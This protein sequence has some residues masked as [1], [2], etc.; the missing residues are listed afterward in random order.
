MRVVCVGAMNIDIQGF[1]KAPINMRD[2]NPGRIE[3]CPGGVTRNIAENMARLGLDV[4]MVSVTGDDDFGRIIRDSCTAVGMDI[5]HV[6]TLPGA[7]SSAYL[8]TTDADG[9]MLNAVS[10]MRILK[11]MGADFIERHRSL[12]ETADAVVLD[13]GLSPEALDRLTEICAGK[14][15]FADPVSITYAGV[16]KPFLSRLCLVKM[17]SYEAEVL[18][19]MKIRTDDDLEKAADVMLSRGLKVAVITLG[20]RG[21]FYKDTEGRTLISPCEEVRPVSTTGA[22]DAF[23]AGMVYGFAH[24]LSPE[25][26]LRI[27]ARCARFALMSEQTVS[28]ELSESAILEVQ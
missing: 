25:R 7:R 14:P 16:L 13:P 8:V 9:D 28:P 12:L 26:T 6:E 20:S 10:D 3:M 11:R 24:G 27:A 21:A 2:S 17:N 15:I 18:S 5:T 22:G 4:H 19:D 1:S 23:S